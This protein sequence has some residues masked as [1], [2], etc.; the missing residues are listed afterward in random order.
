M[1][2]TTDPIDIIKKGGHRSPINVIAP[3][4]HARLQKCCR[5]FIEDL[6]IL[7]RFQQ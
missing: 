5:N 1:A 4:N 7:R 6:N 2:S 3:T